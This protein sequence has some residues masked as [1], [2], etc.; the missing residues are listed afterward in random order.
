MLHA[1]TPQLQRGS[2]EVV[3]DVITAWRKEMWLCGCASHRFFPIEY[4]N[5]KPP[6]RATEYHCWQNGLLMKFCG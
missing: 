4:T 3:S 5:L 1:D 2:Y 6:V